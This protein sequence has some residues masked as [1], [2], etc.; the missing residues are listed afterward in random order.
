MA[1]DRLE[2]AGILEADADKTTMI[3]IDYRLHLQVS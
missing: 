1:L 2:A 3:V